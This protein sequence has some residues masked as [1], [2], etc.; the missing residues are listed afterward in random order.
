MYRKGAQDAKRAKRFT[1]LVR[2][3][4]VAAKQGGPD[5][6]ANPRLRAAIASAKS[7]SVPKDNIER[8]LKKASGAG[9]DAENYDELSY[10][11]F[12]PGGVAVIVDAVTDNRNRTAAEVRSIFNKHGG[13]LGETGSVNYLFQRVG[14]IRY[15]A[16]AASQDDMFEA[17]LEGGADDCTMD[18]DGHEVICAPDSLSDTGDALS[19]R[20]GPPEVAEIGWRPQTTIPIDEEKAETL[21]KMLEALDDCDDVQL[22]A[23]NYDVADDVLQKLSA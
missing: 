9:A 16:D 15:P 2:E 14:M 7:Q 1:K 12:G 19:S 17:A 20:F 4:I 22:V 3:I 11:G 13:T 23:A 6:D 5:P 18:S 8:A 10:E 21:F